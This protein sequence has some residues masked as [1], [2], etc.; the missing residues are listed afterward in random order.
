M[1]CRL[2]LVGALPS[3][4]ESMTV[5]RMRSVVIMSR[6][7]PEDLRLISKDVSAWKSPDGWIQS[8]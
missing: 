1:L 4:G 6:Q 2:Q 5:L 3:V 8:V 7:F